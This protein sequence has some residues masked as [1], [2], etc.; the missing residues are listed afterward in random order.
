MLPLCYQIELTTG[1]TMTMHKNLKRLAT[2]AA[3]IAAFGASAPAHALVITLTATGNA[4]ADAG[5]RRA[6]SFWESTFSDSV[7]V[8]IKSGFASLGGSI[9]GQAGSTDYFTNFAAMKAALTADATS[10]DDA[11]MVAGLPGG[12]SYSRYINRTTTNFADHVQSGITDMSMTSANAKAIGLLA[13]NSAAVDAEITFSSDFAFDFDP[14]DGIGA[15]LIDFVGV[16]LHELGHAMGFVSGVDVLDYNA[17]GFPDSAYNPYTTLLD[18]TRCSSASQAAGADIDWRAG[19][20]AK[21][22]AIDGNCTALVSDAWSTGETFGDGRQASHWK[23]DRGIGIMDPT[24]APRGSA[25]VVTA[26]DIQA[27]DVIGWTLRSNAVPEPASLLLA[28]TGLL[29][30]AGLRRRR[31]AA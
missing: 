5:F 23:D 15:G 4:N 10:V 6:A 30:I 1:S 26:R 29:G 20:A 17:P 7:T 14:T 11:T 25:M 18:F 31:R 3:V 22:F 12:S 27:F 19:R 24:A 13:A 16:A 9:L 21:D 8:N 28:G 2:C